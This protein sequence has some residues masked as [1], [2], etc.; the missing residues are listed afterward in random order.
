MGVAMQQQVDRARTITRVAG[1]GVA[2]DPVQVVGVAEVLVVV[3]RAPHRVVVDRAE[4]QPAVLPVRPE[5]LGEPRQLRLPDPAI[6]VGV[7]VALGHGRVQAGH[8]QLQIGNLEQGPRLSWH[9]LR[10]D[11]AFQ[12]GC[13]VRRVEP[14]KHIRVVLPFRP[15]RRLRLSF[16]AFLGG[17]VRRA[18]R[19]VDV[20]VSRDHRH[21]VPG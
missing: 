3:H 21:P 11:I 8:D 4:H 10:T 7:L 12:A 17:E 2:D 16:V 9:E 19:P 14:V 6:V 15:V 13:V 18:H 5:P 20:M 1:G